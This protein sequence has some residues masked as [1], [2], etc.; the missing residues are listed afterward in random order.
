MPKIYDVK[1]TDNSDAFR[2][3]LPENIKMALT[4]IGMAGE[5]NAK[6]HIT[7]VIYDTPQSPNYK[8]TGRL[9]NS[10]THQVVDDENS[11]YIGT[12]VEY[13]IPVE[14]G[15]SRMKPRPFIAPAAT[16]HS[17]EYKQLAKEALQT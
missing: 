9:R 13:A 14:M 17:E 7:K 4:A 1:I 2:N 12:N 10:I 3:A 15:T 16:Q 5:S 6:E 11:V 8:R